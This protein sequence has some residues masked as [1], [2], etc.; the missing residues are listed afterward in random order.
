MNRFSRTKLLLGPEAMERLQR[1]SVIVAGLGAVGSYA[2]E[3][4]SR[5]G[6]G[7]LTLVDFDTVHPSNQN[8]QLYALESTQGRPKVEVACERVRDIN[9]DCRVEGRRLFI[10]AT[11]APALVENRPDALID[12]IDSVSPKVQLLAAA[13]TAGVPVLSSMGAATRMDFRHIQVADLANTIGCPLARL[14]RKRLRRHG[15]TTGVTCVFSTETP[16][17]PDPTIPEE[18]EEPVFKAGRPRRTL[19]SL[20]YLTGIFGLIAA[21]E[22]IRWLLDPSR[23][24]SVEPHPPATEGH[25]PARPVS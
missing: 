18:W 6:V 4:L 8:R 5:A 20:S 17:E 9:P 1:A 3:A 16:R 22:V 12:A 25:H 7:A 24:S 11:T 14:I 23:P 2:V 19:G 15:I 10:D 21:G 13:V